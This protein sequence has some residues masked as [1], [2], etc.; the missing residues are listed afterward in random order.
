MKYNIQTIIDK[1]DKEFPEG[2]RPEV[3]FMTVNRNFM[4]SFLKD[5]LT[6][7]LE[8]PYNV[9]EWKKIGIERGYWDYFK[10]ETL[11][12]VLDKIPLSMKRTR[13]EVINIINSHR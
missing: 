8:I 4:R 10:A 1:F 13:K 2:S 12:E 6:S 9:S 5:S 7:M 11:N 3:S